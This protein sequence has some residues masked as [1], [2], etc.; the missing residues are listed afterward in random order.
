MCIAVSLTG[1]SYYIFRHK[2]NP[3]RAAVL[4]PGHGVQNVMRQE[5]WEIHVLG[6]D[7]LRSADNLKDL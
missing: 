5:V 7:T 3:I 2:V 4:G 1:S 6:H